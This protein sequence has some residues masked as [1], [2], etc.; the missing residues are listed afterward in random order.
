MLRNYLALLFAITMLLACSDD[1]HSELEK[2]QVA[3]PTSVILRDVFYEMVPRY[4]SATGYT[5][6]SRNIEI[7]TSQSATINVL[8][9]NEGDLVTKG[10]LLI[11]LDES[12]LL[13]S[14]R[15]AESAMAS[16]RIRLKD[17]EHDLRNATQL[18]AKRV[19][20]VDQLRKSQ[21]QHQLAEAQLE[22]AKSELERQ[23]ARKPYHKIESPID[24]RVVKRW[25]E[26]GDLAVIGKPLL[27]LEAVDGLEFETAIP[28]KWVNSLHIGDSYSLIIHNR[29][30]PMK[31]RVSQI[32]NSVD[33]VTQTCQ[34]KLS[35][36][37][38][39][40]IEAGLSGQVDFIIAKD[41]HL[42]LETTALIKRAG[43]F[44]VFRVE[45]SKAIF[46]PVNFERKWQSY[47]VVLS[48]LSEKDKVVVNPPTSLRDGEIVVSIEAD[49]HTQ[50]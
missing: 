40:K 29:Q 2:Q 31:A 28:A 7:S 9:V 44:G 16:A 17:F 3:D 22:Q 6:V 25:V 21:V 46:T 48:G 8:S 12:E 5:S 38:P 14:I 45:D 4:Y 1:K 47:Y 34:V 19:I 33:R 26:Q 24:A 39:R 41:K 13:T 10:E 36:L 15:Q 18:E 32:V 27:Q 35:L 49:K 42:L 37:E 30:E 23:L 43:V 11:S 20:T 50:G